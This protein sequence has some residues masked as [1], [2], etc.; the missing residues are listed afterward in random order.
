M[1]WTQVYNP[2]G[3]ELLS[4]LAAAAPVVVLLGTLAFAGW[5]APRSAAAGLLTALAV[6]IGIYGMPWRSAV[7]AAGYGACFGLF[8]IGWIV[9]TAVFLYMHR[10]N[11]MLIGKREERM[12]AGR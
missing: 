12:N 5:S 9:F 6:A 4:V 2:T 3:N 7:A 11:A 1:V 10:F 8:P